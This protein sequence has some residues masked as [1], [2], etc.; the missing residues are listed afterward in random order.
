MYDLPHTYM[1]AP[2]GRFIRG[3]DAQQRAIHA[4]Q[5]VNKK[6]CKWKSCQHTP[7]SFLPQYLKAT[8]AASF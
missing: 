8:L 5:H 6:I 7:N 3:V 4:K 1:R 2:D